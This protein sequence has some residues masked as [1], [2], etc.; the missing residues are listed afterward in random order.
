MKTKDARIVADKEWVAKMA[1]SVKDDQSVIME[2]A[3]RIESKKKSVKEQV[4]ELIDNASFGKEVM[5]TEDCLS[6]TTMAK[7]LGMSGATKLQNELTN[8]GIIYFQSGMFHM[9]DK[10]SGYGLSAYKKYKHPGA[11]DRL[12]WT[13]KGRQW[14]HNLVKRGILM[15]EPCPPGKHTKPIDQPAKPV[16]EEIPKATEAK[17]KDERHQMPKP[18]RNT[19]MLMNL[20]DQMQGYFECIISLAKQ[21]VQENDESYCRLLREDVR[22]INDSTPLMM[23]QLENE[24]YKILEA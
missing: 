8:L 22:S 23:R 12:Y 3:Q 18:V 7:D 16:I 20:I 19:E 21:C 24:C 13:Q 15:T 9:A 2:L 10:Y 5:Y 17:P 6:M 11:L 1:Q 14:L 4:D